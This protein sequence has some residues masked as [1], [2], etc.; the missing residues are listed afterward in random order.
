MGVFFKFLKKWTVRIILS[1]FLL[2]VLLVLP[3]RWVNP[4]MTSFML[5]RKI[6]ALYEQ[7]SQ[8]QIEYRWRDWQQLSPLLLMAM[9][10][11]EDQNFPNHIGIDFKSINQALKDK[12]KSG[13]LRGASTISQQ[14]AKNLYLWPDR[15]MWRKAIEAY[16]TLL[17]EICLDKKR[18]LEIYANIAEFGDGVY[19]A[20]AASWHHFS[21]PA[22]GLSKNQ[23]ALLAATLPSPRRYYAGHPTRYLI[24]RSRWIRRQMDQLGGLEFLAA[25]EPNNPI[26]NRSL[27]RNR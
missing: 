4:P 9:I 24:K 3:L 11:S 2:S 21:I 14:L 27:H 22:T 6:E 1:L 7:Q 25:I 16:F 23:A 13:R 19:G 15:S 10:A 12:R 26:D 20:E 17:L 5:I 8:F 18:I